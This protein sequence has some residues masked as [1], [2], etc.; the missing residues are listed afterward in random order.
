MAEGGLAAVARWGQWAESGWMTGGWLRLRRWGR[1]WARR[2][3]WIGVGVGLFGSGVRLGQEFSPV[4]VRFINDPDLSAWL[5]PVGPSVAEAGSAPPAGAQAGRP[6]AG[7]TTSRD[8]AARRGLE[9]DGAP[10]G[11]VTEEAVT[12]AINVNVAS[13]EQLESLPGIG[14]V[15][16]RRIV[17][18]RERVGPFERVD[19]LVEV[20]GVGPRVLERLKGRVVVAG[21]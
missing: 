15:L 8:E 19:D 14:P 20:P 11:A 5:T 4:D 2:A 12:P 10:C 1:L 7:E 13:A 9:G 21:P 16:A 3:V 6:G 18:W 17:E